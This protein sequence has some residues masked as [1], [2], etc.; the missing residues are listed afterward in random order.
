VAATPTPAAI[1]V[2]GEADQTA[3][4]TAV[5][6]HLRRGGSPLA[7]EVIVQPRRVAG[8]YA[9]VLVVPG[10]GAILRRTGS[11]WE[12][13]ELGTAFDLESLSRQGV[14]PGLLEG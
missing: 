6:Q 3:M 13:V 1:G 5:R 11:G 14:P 2:I 7:E 8:D 12:V 9:Y 10:A 4:L